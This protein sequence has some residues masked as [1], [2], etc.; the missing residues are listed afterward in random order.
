MAEVELEGNEVLVRLSLLESLFVGR[1]RVRLPVRDL[2]MVQVEDDPLHTLSRWRVPGLYWPGSLV[3][4]TGRQCGR[5]EL[6]L[7]HAGHAALVLDLAT[8]PWG[9]VVV[10]SPAAGGLAAE[11]AAVLLERGPGGGGRS[12]RPGLNGGALQRR[13]SPR[14][15]AGPAGAP[16]LPA[17]TVAVA[18]S[19]MSNRTAP[20]WR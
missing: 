15:G 5:R 8:G 7:A 16:R 4:G 18:R 13:R 1:R 19:A 12:P 6:A 3:L 17:E 10:T 20:A 14:P 9:R 2:T 11:L